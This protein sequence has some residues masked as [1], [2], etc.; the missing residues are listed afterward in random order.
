MKK[1]DIYG[2]GN[3]LVDLV[4]EVD[5]KFLSDNEVEKGLMTLVE[6]DRQKQLISQIQVSESMMKG[7][8]SAANTVVAASQFGGTC[9]YSCKVSNDDFGTFYLKDLKDNGVDTKLIPETAPAG[10]TGRCLVMTTPDAER[11]MNTFLGITSD[12]SVAEI[13]EEAIKNSTYIYSEG[14]LVPSPSGRD[15]MKKAMEVARANGVKVA[16]SFS[17]PS[18]VKFFNAEM[19][20]VVGTGVDLLFCN[21]E[22]AMLFTDT[23]N[24]LDA[25][26]VL[27]GVAKKFVITMGKNGA[28]IFDGDT[29]VDIEPYAVD[30]I[31]TNGA[32][33]MFAGAFMYGIT[34]G[35]SYAEAGKLASLASSKVVSQ[36][37]PRLEWSQAKEILKH[38][39]E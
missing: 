25:R 17:D 22:E 38:L 32:G 14:Y 13:D 31:D 15:A 6:E 2:I 1:Y 30:A 7:G 8:G 23:K 21:E 11:T 34:H 29:F 36:F 19:K 37:G 18:M 12:F 4:F 33:D 39:T 24:I 3:A 16:L 26:E 27:K 5:E 20:E 10:I 28:M 9:Y 35:H